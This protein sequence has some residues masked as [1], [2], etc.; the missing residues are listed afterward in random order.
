MNNRKLSNM[1]WQ[2]FADNKDRILIIPI[3]S[4]EQ[5]GP[6]LPLSVDTIIAEHFADLLAE[7]VGGVVAPV[8]SYGYKSK[9]RSGGGPLFPGTIDLNGMT[10]QSLLVDLLLEYA[11]DGYSKIFIMN[12]HFE[13]E[14]FVEE[15]MDLASRKV[16]DS[17]RFVMSNWWDPVP[18]AQID[19]L[20]DEV[21]FPGWA[22]EHAAITETSLMMYFAPELV[23][24][25]K[26]E[27]IRPITPPL[28]AE[29]PVR[30]DL[31][32][33]TGVLATAYSSSAEKGQIIVEAALPAL[34]KI[35]EASFGSDSIRA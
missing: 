22:L 2:E 28:Y 32:P 27:N 23:R 35:A 15:A 11:A 6:H 29:Y 24:K 4:T 12:A 30:K 10:L 26:I 17:A 25:D 19:L 20:F 14:A 33:E 5:H 7:E 16:G 31:I 18:Q 8:L 1:T 3:G 21:P 13:N 34:K 9:P